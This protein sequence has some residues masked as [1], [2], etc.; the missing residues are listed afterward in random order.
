MTE[1]NPHRSAIDP[2]VAALLAAFHE[3]T[4]LKLERAPVD[5]H[6]LYEHADGKLYELNED[7]TLS[8]LSPES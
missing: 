2:T 8:E 6:P 3:D 7:G 1:P 4:P 5:S